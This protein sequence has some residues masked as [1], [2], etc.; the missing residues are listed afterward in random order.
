MGEMLSLY[1]AAIEKW[2]C[3]A[4]VGMVHEEIGELLEACGGLLKIINKFNREDF[5]QV[6]LEDVLEEVV[7]VEIMLEQFTIILGLYSGSIDDITAKKNLLREAKLDR[8]ENRLDLKKDS[9]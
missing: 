2:G 8:L 4:Q 3:D 7:D 5:E 1:A 9:E 6:G